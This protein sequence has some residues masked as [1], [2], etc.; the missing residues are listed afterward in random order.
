MGALTSYKPIARFGAVFT[1]CFLSAMAA[2]IIMTAVE[3][4]AVV[5]GGNPGLSDNRE[6]RIFLM[7]FTVLYLTAGIII[8]FAEGILFGLFA[9]LGSDEDGPPG[10]GERAARIYAGALTGLLFLLVLFLLSKYF[11]ATFKNKELA[12][13]VLAVIIMLLLGLMYLL[14]KALR[15]LAMELLTRWGG[16]LASPR[17]AIFATVVAVILLAGLALL[18]FR[19]SL[20]GIP[21]RSLLKIAAFIAFNGCG[22]FFLRWRRVAERSP[23]WLFSRGGI[24]LLI[25]VCYGLVSQAMAPLQSPGIRAAMGQSPIVGPMAR[26]LFKTSARLQEQKGGKLSRK[27]ALPLKRRNPR[28]PTG[29]VLIILDSV[30]ADRIGAYGY[31]MNTTPRIDKLSSRAIRFTWAFSPSCLT[32]D[33]VPAI[34]TGKMPLAHDRTD[35]YWPQYGEDNIFISELLKKAGYRT[36]GVVA[37][38]YL[39]RRKGLAKGFDRWANSQEGRPCRETQHGTSSREVTDRAIGI[40]K[41]TP[42]SG[43][44]FFLMVHYRD[45]QYKHIRHRGFESFGPR[46]SDLYNG[47][48]AFT[49]HHLG[50]LL[51]AI[52]ARPDTERIALFLVGDR[53]GR[54]LPSGSRRPRKSLYNA[55]IRVPLLMYLPQHKARQISQPVS[56]LDIFPT[57]LSLAGLSPQPGLKGRNLL[58]HVS[59]SV[60]PK[61]I[62]LWAEMQRAKRFNIQYALIDWPWKL[63]FS[64][65]LGRIRLFN[66]E[67]DPLEIKNLRWQQPKRFKKMVLKVARNQH[68]RRYN[69]QERPR[70][71]ADRVQPRRPSDIRPPENAPV[72]RQPGDGNSSAGTAPSRYKTMNTMIRRAPTTA[73]VRRAPAAP[74]RPAPTAPVRRAPA[75]PIRPAPKPKSNFL[76]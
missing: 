40:L 51:D 36:A 48:I 70:R 2:T 73:P 34:L 61:P 53:G 20:A 22:Y 16:R 50:R 25:I 69:D 26:F 18:L 3:S 9:A 72:V 65:G 14:F 21:G 46:R 17:G 24:I 5:A 56:V 42:A 71:G 54:F 27:A 47:E 74:V 39:S 63:I 55:L 58:S 60:N 75:A 41:S 35:H 6:L 28:R 32:K 52:K 19:K 59:K 45:P 23:R 13:F 8:G 62:P 31:E 37:H 66:L 11:I 76:H 12:A 15:E 1:T 49:D 44:K 57:I 67:Q 68:A 4:L 38:P 43:G 7:R 30:S 29:I 64:P 10:Y 33:A